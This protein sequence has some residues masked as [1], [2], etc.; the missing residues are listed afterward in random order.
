[1]TKQKSSTKKL[2]KKQQR[3]LENQ[4]LTN[5]V[6][7]WQKMYNSVRA[8]TIEELLLG[9]KIASNTSIIKT[10]RS[11]V[12]P[13]RNR[14]IIYKELWDE[15]SDFMNN[16]FYDTL[17]QCMLKFDATQGAQFITYYTNGLKN[18]RFGMLNSYLSK[19]KED[20]M[21]QQ[22]FIPR[23]NTYRCSLD[24][25]VSYSSKMD[26]ENTL[27]DLVRDHASLID[28][29]VIKTSYDELAEI[30]R[31]VVTSIEDPVIRFALSLGERNIFEW[32][33]SDTYKKAHKNSQD[34]KLM[35]LTDDGN[36]LFGY[37]A[38]TNIEI[39]SF[40]GISTQAINT[41]IK[42][43]KENQFF[44]DIEPYKSQIQQTFIDIV[45]AQT[46]YGSKTWSL[47]D[48]EN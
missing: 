16:L 17:R 34:L 14:E 30:L 43:Y 2:T 13:Y 46:D 21:P 4:A 26:K 1:M 27:G 31:R 42:E 5:D 37:P 38:L 23:D 39:A 9:K 32:M 20:F 36:N 47:D 18:P 35:W 7:E 8:G 12:K 10:F 41:R 15:D 48:G 6:V 45:K 28:N 11:A 19:N 22:N 33:I 29:E 25:N 44:D 24:Q 40:I 3:A